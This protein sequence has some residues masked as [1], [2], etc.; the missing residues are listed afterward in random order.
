MK[1]YVISLTG[2]QVVDWLNK[3]E[4]KPENI[5]ILSEEPQYTNGDFLIFYYSDK[6]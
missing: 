6:E 3:K 2:N 5:K 1:W 4:L